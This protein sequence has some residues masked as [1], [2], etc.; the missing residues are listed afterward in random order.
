MTQLPARPAGSARG[1]RLAGSVLVAI[2]GAIVRLG[3]LAGR[4]A[5]SRGPRAE[6]VLATRDASR[7]TGNLA[8]IAAGIARE[9]P[10]VRH[11][12]IGYQ[13]RH[14]IRGRMRTVLEA[15]RL[16]YHLSAA[17]LL[18]A[19]DWLF[20]MFA[21]PTRRG[22]ARIQVWHAAGA[23][24]RFGF[25]VLD[26]TLG[27]GAATDVVRMRANWDA[28][29]V[30][31][32]AAAPHFADAFRIAPERCTSV[33][34]LPRTDAQYDAARVA[35]TTA[36]LRSRYGLDPRRRTLLY[37]PTFRGETMRDATSPT[38]LDLGALRDGLAQDWQVLLRLHPHVRHLGAAV[39]RDLAGFVTD[40]SDWPEMNDLMPLADLLVTDYSSVIF[41]FSLLGRPMAFFTPDLERYTGD[42]GFYLDIPG[43]LPGPALT[44]TSALLEH[45]RSGAWTHGGATARD[46][47][48]R[49][50]DM[51]DGESTGRFLAM[52]VEPALRG[53][54]VR[55]DPAPPADR[56]RVLRAPADD[57]AAG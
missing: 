2:G 18:V 12:V 21:V 13:T 32:A 33:I 22:T 52:V 39:A 3:A 26:T 9:L 41:E 42:R 27:P 5:T 57:P 53:A 45:I 56:R 4:L 19:D 15:A 31:S 46:F 54:S 35:A 47:A 37:A 25:S 50:W 8:A 55:L 6:V 43:D 11:R 23:F 16:G 40:V 51:A 1:R 34:G 7:V 29:L 38:D 24:K 17:R 10:G 28:V 14:G 44:S 48:E 30:S 36:T 49:W 20:P